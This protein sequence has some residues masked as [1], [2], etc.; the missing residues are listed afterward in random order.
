MHRR[1]LGLLLLVVVMVV[2]S[3][4][5][6]TGTPALD[7]S[8]PNTAFRDGTPIKLRVVATKADGQVGAGT[9]VITTDV[10]VVKEEL[11]TLDEFGTATFTFECNVATNPD[12]VVDSANLKLLW[13][14]KPAVRLDRAIRLAPKPMSTG[15]GGTGG[16]VPAGCIS[17]KYSRT[18]TCNATINPGPRVAC[19]QQLPGLIPNCADIY[20]CDGMRMTRNYNRVLS[21]GGGIPTTLE[22]EF[23]VPTYRMSFDECM[24]QKVGITVRLNGSVMN[25]TTPYTYGYIEPSGEYFAYRM[26]DLEA[27]RAMEDRECRDTSDGGTKLGVW[28]SIPDRFRDGALGPIYQSVDNSRFFFISLI[29]P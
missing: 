4:C 25:A 13:Q 17:E 8:G 11:V 19:C 20:V 16:G 22:L 5:G 2:V 21:D 24:T 9:V 29:A 26:G 12:C 7:V 28:H 23:H 1:P 15:D 6:Q 14:T 3:Q 27:Y 18:G 10:G